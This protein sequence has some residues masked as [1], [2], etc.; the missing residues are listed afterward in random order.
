M[1]AFPALLGALWLWLTPIL[2]RWLAVAHFGVAVDPTGDRIAFSYDQQSYDIDD[3]LKLRFVRD[4][5][6]MDEVRLSEIGRMTRQGGSDLFLHGSF[7]SR[8]IRFTKKQKR[9]ECIWAIRNSGLSSA[10][11]PV[12]FGT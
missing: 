3:Y 1:L 6:R 5:P 2:F 12:E 11:M 10:P 7:G 8:R 4:L 9:D